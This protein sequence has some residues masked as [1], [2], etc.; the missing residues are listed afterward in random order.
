MTLDVGSTALF[1]S[2]IRWDGPVADEATAQ[3]SCGVMHVH[4]RSRG[5]PNGM[6]V[7]LV[8]TA[9]RVL[10]GTGAQAAL[11]ANARGASIGAVHTDVAR[12][13]LLTVSQYLA[14][15]CAQ[16]DE[17]VPIEPGG[18]PFRSADGV[19]FEVDTLDPEAWR[20][21]WVRAGAPPRAAG[22]GWAPFQFRYATASAP[23]PE[24]L[25]ERTAAL[26]YAELA[27]VAGATGVSICPLMPLENR[28]R[29]AP[30]DLQS[31]QGTYVRKEATGTLPLDGMV[32]LEAGRRVQ[33]P[34]AAHLLSLLGARV[35][36]IEPPGGDPLR[37]M[38]PMCGDTSARWLAL[39]RHKDAA[40]VDIKS[41]SGR[42]DLRE[43]AA[44]A[45]VFLHNWAPG[46]AE[47]LGL[48][49]DDLHAVNP[50]LVY[51]Y[52]SGYANRLVDPPLGT[53]FMV[54][55]R[56]G[57]GAAIRPSDQPPSPSLMAL[58]DVTGGLLGAH[59]I[60]GALLHRE[61]TG[62]GCRVESSLLAAADLLQ[63][64]AVESIARGGSGRPPAGFRR[65][66]RT[67]DGW[68]AP[69][70]EDAARAASFGDTL[71]S[72]STADAVAFLTG[73][74]LRAVPVTDDL[75]A[76]PADPR[77]A[78]CLRFD[79]TGSVEVLTPWSFQ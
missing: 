62:H 56:T 39:N 3:A 51:A 25:F 37:G 35:T 2:A 1:P 14:A 18:P 77:F 10:A 27:A 53:D 74:G 38:P 58:V 49:A 78:D 42:A 41:P 64:N 43:L 68:C 66:L 8:G 5:E 19:L 50:G 59:A 73:Q 55:A 72:L 33:A 61:R 67:A 70:D 17:A 44:G 45:D 9:A 7:D 28:E 71:A 32:V 79:A 26:P 11:L 63:A 21:F 34:L 16:D 29:E 40:E 12:S 15:A 60:T 20:D 65:P 6:G 75:R 46:K 36:R 52:T 76:L 31:S 48:G 4:G 57:L 54:Q 30:W 24:V 23:L 47:Q 22:I 69:T 13:A